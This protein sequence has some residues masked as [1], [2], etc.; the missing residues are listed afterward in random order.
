[1]RITAVDPILLKGGEAYN[2][3]ACGLLSWAQ[4]M[5]GKNALRA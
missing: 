4:A 3:S 1:M 5:C 2:A